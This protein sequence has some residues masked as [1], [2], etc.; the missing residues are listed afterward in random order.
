[1][2][3]VSDSGFL[4]DGKDCLHLSGKMSPTLLEEGVGG[5]VAYQ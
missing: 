5:K 2:P 4:G 1:M 3:V